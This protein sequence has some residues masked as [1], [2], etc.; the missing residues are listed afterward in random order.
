MHRADESPFAAVGGVTVLRRNLVPGL[1]VRADRVEALLG[2][3]RDR[4]Q[5]G[6]VLAR[7]P[8]A[9]R[10]DR[11]RNRDLQHRLAVRLQLQAR[12]LQREPVGLHRDDLA[13]QERHDRV[14]CFVHARALHVGGNAEHVR[15]RRQLARSAAEH[16][17][18]AREVVEQDEAVG[19]QQ[20]MVIGQR[21][22]AAA[23]AQVLR[24]LRGGRDEHLG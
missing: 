10:R 14:E 11:R 16:H 5:P 1:P 17:A 2:R 7:G 23:E 19:E 18:A 6:A 12:V 15:V 20:R 4:E 24:A 21:V 3:R 13:A 9:G 8:R 22:D